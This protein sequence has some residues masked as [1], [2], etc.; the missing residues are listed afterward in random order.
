MVVLVV[1]QGVDAQECMDFVKMRYLFFGDRQYM[2]T[3]IQSEHLS[4]LIFC[5]VERVDF[6]AY[7]TKVCI[8]K[9]L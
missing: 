4:H 9:F 3:L 7:Y 8:N 6:K 5:T 1:V 2:N